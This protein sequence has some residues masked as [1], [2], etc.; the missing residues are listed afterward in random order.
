MKPEQKLIYHTPKQQAPLEK[1]PT[2][3]GL[4][5]GPPILP[6]LTTFL[7]ARKTVTS[8]IYHFRLG[9]KL[10]RNVATHSPSFRVEGGSKLPPMVESSIVLHSATKE[11]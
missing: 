2:G 6:F 7:A 3:I 1:E 5:A 10:I 9:A 8:A 4:I 11:L